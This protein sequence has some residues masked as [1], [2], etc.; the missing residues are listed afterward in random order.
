MSV[1]CAAALLVAI[2]VFAGAPGAEGQVLVSAYGG[3]VHTRPADVKLEQPPLETSL[4]FPEV[5]FASESL[6]SPIYYGYRI[7]A[8]VPGTRWLF[9]EGELI[10]AKLFARADASP[11]GAGRLLGAEVSG[12]SFTSVFD[13]FAISHGMNFVLVNAL[14]RRPLAADERWLFTA[15]LGAGPMIPHPEIVIGAESD[16]GYQLGGI[17]AQLAGGLERQI[18]GRLSVLAEYK[19]AVARLDVSAPQGRV[20]LT[21]RSHHLAL[22]AGFRF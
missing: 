1:R 16:D 19:L 8:S 5:L 11:A 2:G 10:H 15:R 18:S 12:I 6:K 7:A 9:I 14:L 21:A 20:R 17:G 4:T 3:A 13:Q 22:G